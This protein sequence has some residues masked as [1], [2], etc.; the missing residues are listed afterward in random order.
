MD[1]YIFQLN[2]DVT[3]SSVCFKNRYGIELAGD[4]YRA[5]DLDESVCHPGIVIGPPYGGVKEQ[6]PGVWANELAQ[7]GFVVL[8]FDPSFNG[9]SQGKQRHIS[10]PDLFVEDFHAAVDYLG[11]RPFIDRERIGAVG[12]CGSGGFALSAASVDPRIKAVVTASFFDVSRVTQKGFGEG[13][14]DV[15]WYQ[16]TEP[17]ALQRYVDFEETHQALG[18]KTNV[19]QVADAEDPLSREFAEFYNT[20]RGYHPN[21]IAHFTVTS[22]MSFAN[23]PLLTNIKRIS[24]RPILMIAGENAASKML[25]DEAFEMAA[26]PKEKL[27][28]PDCNHVD[29]YDDTEKIPF[30]EIEAFLK[31]S[32]AGLS[33]RM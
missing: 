12:I 10:S 25:T 1:N 31:E 5:K 22:N 20:K 11:T 21:A 29:L 8:T 24:P 23:F 14:S 7:R 17:M 13:L 16:M 3:R 30:D 6:G 19:L 15:E 18:A 33:G 2:E 32:F 9:Y 27:V 28:I 26:E 4:L